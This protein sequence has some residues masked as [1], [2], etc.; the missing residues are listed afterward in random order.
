MSIGLKLR[1]LRQRAGNTLKMQSELLGVSINTIYRWEH[2][3]AT[4]RAGVLKKMA[5]YYNI[6][7]DWLNADGFVEEDASCAMKLSLPAEDDEQ[8]LLSMYRKLPNSCKYKILGYVERVYIE[9]MEK[10]VNN[11]E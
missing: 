8:Q 4:P 6:S 2:N 5:D 10:N 3:L 9:A 1:K 7:L 11:Q